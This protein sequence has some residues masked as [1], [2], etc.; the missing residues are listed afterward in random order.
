MPDDPF[1]MPDDKALDTARML[2]TSARTA[3]LGTLTAEGAPYVTR[4]AVGLAAG[5]LVSLMSD[6]S[7]HAQALHR[8]PRAGLLLGEAPDR[9]DPLAFARLSLVAKA[10]V[11]ARE[12]PEHALIRADWLRL[13]PKSALYVDFADFR[14]VAFALSGGHLNA[15]FGRAFL[16]S[17][18]QLPLA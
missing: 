3:A 13:H 15:G 10:E 8:D 17:P 2:L 4:I 11:V 18:A 16:L 9:G 7:L 12:T 6:L 5:R 1:R 14:F